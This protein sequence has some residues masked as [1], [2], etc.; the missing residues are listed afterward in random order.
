MIF[1]H[2]FA[3]LIGCAFAS[4]SN[5]QKEAN[6]CANDQQE[7]HEILNPMIR[8]G[9]ASLNANQTI[10]FNRKNYTLFNDWL[11]EDAVG[12]TRNEV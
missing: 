9:S 10:A 4:A 12:S 8:A 2:W 6:Y 1:F 5:A 11:Q 3:V 7:V